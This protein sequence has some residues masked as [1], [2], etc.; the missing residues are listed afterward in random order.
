M[1]ALFDESK[2]ISSKIQ[3]ELP[4]GFKV[5]SLHS[6]DYNKGF[7]KAL[8]HLTTTGDDGEAAFLDRFHYLKAHNYEYFTVVIEDVAKK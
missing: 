4:K 6:D 7:L 5:R 1:A 8:S 2:F 3:K